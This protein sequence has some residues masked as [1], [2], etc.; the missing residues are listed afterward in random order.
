MGKRSKAPLPRAR[1]EGSGG[2][3]EGSLAATAFSLGL[4]FAR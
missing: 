3:T 1:G 2:A 4:G